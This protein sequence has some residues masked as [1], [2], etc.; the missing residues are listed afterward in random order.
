VRD[1]TQLL[2]QLSF[3]AARGGNERC[4]DSGRAGGPGATLQ[5]AEMERSW[6]LRAFAHVLVAAR[7]LAARTVPPSLPQHSTRCSSSCWMCLPL[8]VLP[9]R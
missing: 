8:L 5:G 1:V 9:Q 3:I 4:L 7:R 6:L 2:S